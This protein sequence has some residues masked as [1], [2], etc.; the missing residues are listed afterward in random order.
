MTRRRRISFLLISIGAVTVGLLIAP[1]TLAAPFAVPLLAQTVVRLSVCPAQEVDLSSGLRDSIGALRNNLAHVRTRTQNF[2]VEATQ[3]FGD[4]F[5][6][7]YRTTCDD[8]AGGTYD[9]EGF[10]T[11]RRDGIFWRDLGGEELGFYDAGCI[12]TETPGQKMCC[13]VSMGEQEQYMAVLG[14]TLTPDVAVVEV[15][16]DNGDVGR[17]AVTHEKFAISSP[18]RANSGRIRLFNRSGLLLDEVALDLSA[19]ARA[20]GATGCIS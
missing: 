20:A 12:T 5:T 8:L 18:H 19:D 2:R 1:P 16:F 7:Y 10:R 6:T 11:L 9:V 14:H 13:S 15:D 17:M 4:G 3:V